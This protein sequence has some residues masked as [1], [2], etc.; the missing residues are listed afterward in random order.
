MSKK[1]GEMKSILD[2]RETK[3]HPISLDSSFSIDELETKIK[4][5]ASHVCCLTKYPIES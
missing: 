1:M 5:G 4:E 2:D 3:V